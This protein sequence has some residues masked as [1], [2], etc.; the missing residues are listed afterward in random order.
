[1]SA[2]DVDEGCL[3]LW[4]RTLVIRERMAAWENAGGEGVE[5]ETKEWLKDH[6]DDLDSKEFKR[7]QWYLQTAD[8]SDFQPI[9][10]SRLEHAGILDTVELMFQ[11]YTTNTKQVA[12]KIFQKII[13][14][15]GHEFKLWLLDKLED[16]NKKELELFQHHLHNADES[17]DGFGPIKRFKLDGADILETVDVMT[18]T[19]H[20]KTRDVTKKILKKIESNKDKVIPETEDQMNSSSP[21]EENELNTIVEEF[22]RKVPKETLTQF[23]DDLISENILNPSEKE[24]IFRN[25]T[26]LNMATCL[27]DIMKD[28]GNSKELISHI[29]TNYPQ[30]L[31]EEQSPSDPGQESS[32]RRFS[33]NT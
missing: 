13:P 8:E 11:M 21:S 20:P 30:L 15:Q 33:G 7:F 14:Y 24:E 26:R 18:K 3:P 16:L 27:V 1:M 31:S 17:K 12:D 2:P 6:L 9:K 5:V 29:Q 19:Y 25:H 10:R 23:T 22:V 4:A 32:E 28:K